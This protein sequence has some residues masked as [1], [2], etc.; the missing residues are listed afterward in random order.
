[1]VPGLRFL[2]RRELAT[3]GSVHI[4]ATANLA[5]VLGIS[6]AKGTPTLIKTR[7]DVTA[8]PSPPRSS[9]CIAQVALCNLQA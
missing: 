8:H 4:Q 3:K 6:V 1:M 5:K 2:L 9:D 7:Q